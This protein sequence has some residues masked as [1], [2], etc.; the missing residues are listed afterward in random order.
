M[1]NSR[2]YFGVDL[3][4]FFAR[5][6]VNKCHH[7]LYLLTTNTQNAP[8]QMTEWAKTV[9]Q[10]KRHHMTFEWYW[11]ELFLTTKNM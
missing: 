3:F 11:T 7:V 2:S 5:L 1:H 8:G 10:I 6:L 9:A 4:S